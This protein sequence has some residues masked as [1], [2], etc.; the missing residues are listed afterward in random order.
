[1]VSAEEWQSARDEPIV[2]QLNALSL[3]APR[4]SL[5]G[6]HI[7]ATTLIAGPPLV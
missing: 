1:V 6:R 7:V 3:T 4:W 5:D 2:P